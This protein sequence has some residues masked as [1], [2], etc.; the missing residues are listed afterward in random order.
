MCQHWW[1]DSCRCMYVQTVTN[2]PPGLHP[3]ASYGVWVRLK[4]HWPLK[5]KACHK[6]RKGHA[7]KSHYTTVEKLGRP[8]RNVKLTH[9]MDK[10]ACTV[11]LCCGFLTRNRSRTRVVHRGKTW[12]WM[13]SNSFKCPYFLVNCGCVTSSGCS[14][15]VSVECNQGVS[16]SQCVLWVAVSTIKSWIV[17]VK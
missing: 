10:V 3:T 9:A 6:R 8:Y 17:K 5:M 2:L 7:K 15:L 12:Q 11:A 4:S 13:E 16:W 14:Q 1:S